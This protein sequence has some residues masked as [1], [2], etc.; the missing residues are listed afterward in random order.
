MRVNFCG[1][2][3]HSGYGRFTCFLVPAMVRQGLD[4]SIIPSYSNEGLAEKSIEPLIKL[5]DPR[6]LNADV[7]VRLSI[8]NPC[9]VNQLHGKRRIFYTML[10]STRLP[11]Y[12]VQSLNTVDEVWT[13][14]H[15]GKQC[16]KESGVTVPVNVVPGG[17]PLELF[18]P[19]IEPAIP[20]SDLFRYLMERKWEHRK[21]YDVAVRA[22]SEEFHDGENVELLLNCMTINYFVTN[23]NVWEALYRLRLN[24]NHAAISVIREPIED[25]HNMGRLYR[26]ANCFLAPTR[27]EG[28]NLPLLEAFACG[29]PCIATDWSAQTEYITDENCILLKKNK[30]VPSVNPNQIYQEY[31]RYGEWIDPD[32]GEL[33]G[34]MRWAYE[35]RSELA[36]Y[37]RTAA[38]DSH[39]WTWDES[40]KKAKAIL[41]R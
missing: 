33:R 39:K 2:T 35:N 27:G 25:Y 30:V 41:E 10:E 12:W 40:A 15:W 5:K 8:A 1:P 31:L 26:S 21:G 22:Y 6:V 7:D 13:P 37:G 4:V 28:W 18:N 32:I 3:G 16:F 38:F 11:P 20:P 17:V 29:V 24:P 14:S 23:F 19:Q 34:K 36:K 9:D